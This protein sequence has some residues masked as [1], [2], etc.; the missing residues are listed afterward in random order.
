[1]PREEALPTLFLSTDLPKQHARSRLVSRAKQR[2]RVRFISHA[3]LPC[4]G[5][6]PVLV[7]KQTRC[8]VPG[9]A[10]LSQPSGKLTLWARK[11]GSEALGHS[12]TI[13]LDAYTN[14]GAV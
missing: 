3:D 7:R 1:M 14:T 5:S 13:L 8:L 2:V 6:D 4:Q 11:A 10:A 12:V 9:S